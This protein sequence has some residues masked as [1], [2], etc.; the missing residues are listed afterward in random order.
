MFSMVP[1]DCLL[2]DHQRLRD[3][4]VAGPF[5]E[6]LQHLD[7]AV[8]QAS[9]CLVRRGRHYWATLHVRDKPLVCIG[10]KLGAHPIP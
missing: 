5:R 4:A 6:L 8:R 2:A 7:L 1:L 10:V 3:L 9:R